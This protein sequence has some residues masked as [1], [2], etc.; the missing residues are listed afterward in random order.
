[1]YNINRTLIQVEIFHYSTAIYFH[2][3]EQSIAANR[4]F[5]C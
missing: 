2:H 5:R 3:A 1:M 4:I